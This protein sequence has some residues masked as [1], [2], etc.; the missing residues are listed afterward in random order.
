MKPGT[1][2]SASSMRTT[3]P[4]E[5]SWSAPLPSSLCL[6]W[7]NTP[8]PTRL[9]MKKPRTLTTSMMANAETK[10]ILS[11]NTTNE[12][13]SLPPMQIGVHQRRPLKARV[14]PLRAYSVDEGATPGAGEPLKRGVLPRAFRPSSVSHGINDFRRA[15]AAPLE[16]QVE[17]AIVD[18]RVNVREKMTLLATTGAAPWRRRRCRAE[19][20]GSRLG[21]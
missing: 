5:N 1:Q 7:A 20:R 16:R 18:P 19:C 11:A 6:V 2:I 8:T 14:S 9:T 3:G 4:S 21:P 12:A 17:A 13:G 10:P 15:P